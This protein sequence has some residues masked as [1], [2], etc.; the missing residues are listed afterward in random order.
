M[1]AKVFFHRDTPCDGGANYGRGNSREPR[2]LKTGAALC[3]DQCSQFRE[4]GFC[5]YI[6]GASSL[7][8]GRNQGA[9]LI[10]RHGQLWVAKL[11]RIT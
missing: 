6:R 9:A 7:L 5:P 10:F 8:S 3:S 2:V 11:D 4:R 1:R